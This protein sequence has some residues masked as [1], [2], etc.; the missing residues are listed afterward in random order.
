MTKGEAHLSE[1]YNKKE[2]RCAF[3]QETTNESTGIIF[4]K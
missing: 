2:M 1:K 3:K 4:V